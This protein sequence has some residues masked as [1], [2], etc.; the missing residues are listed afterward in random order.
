M[1]IAQPAHYGYP[2]SPMAPMK[3][4][5]TKITPKNYDHLKIKEDDNYEDLEISGMSYDH[6]M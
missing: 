2:I 5:E 6:D 4:Q 3:R 1:Q